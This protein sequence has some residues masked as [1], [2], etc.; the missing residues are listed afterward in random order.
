MIEEK[1]EVRCKH[2]VI[3]H[4]DDCVTCDFQEAE[5]LR[6]C[7]YLVDGKVCG[8]YAGKHEEYCRDHKYGLMWDV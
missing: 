7:V 3:L 6:R 4:Y 8:V 1:D 2:G 5:Q